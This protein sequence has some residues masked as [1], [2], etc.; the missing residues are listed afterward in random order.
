MKVSLIVD[1]NVSELPLR[2]SD[3][4][5]I[6]PEQKR[7]QPH[8]STYTHTP[9]SVFIFCTLSVFYH[10]NI[11]DMVKLNQDHSGVGGSDLDT[12]GLSWNLVWF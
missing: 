3:L 1:T 7:V 9:A 6:A 11:R 10:Q 4:V 12:F 5:N 2:A 8:F